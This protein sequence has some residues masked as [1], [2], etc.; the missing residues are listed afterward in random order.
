MCV[1]E[2]PHHFVEHRGPD[3]ADGVDLVERVG[4]GVGIWVSSEAGRIRI[5]TKA[6]GIVEDPSSN[7]V[8]GVPG[9]SRFGVDGSCHEVS[10]AFAH[11]A[12]FQDVEAGSVGRAAG[13][14]IGKAVGIFMDDDAGLEGAVADGVGVV[15]NVHSHTRHLTIGRSC[16][17]GIV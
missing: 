15:P 3:G 14:T 6:F 8:V 4:G 1:D 2:I 13:Q 7:A 9:I 12:C 11:T 17:V 10:P 16:E 5:G